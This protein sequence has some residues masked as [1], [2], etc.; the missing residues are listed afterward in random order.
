MR[1]LQHDAD[2]EPIWNRF[3]T[4]FEPILNLVLETDFE[5]ILNRF[6]ISNRFRPDFEPMSTPFRTPWAAA[7]PNWF[8]GRARQAKDY[9]DDCCGQAFGVTPVAGEEDR[10][11]YP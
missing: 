3:R 6:S 2:S 1:G 10:D 11:P 4:D 9:F 8:R 7:L 5:P